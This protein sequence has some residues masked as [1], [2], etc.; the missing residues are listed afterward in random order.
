MSCD[1]PVTIQNHLLHHTPQPDWGKDQQWNWPSS[2][3]GFNPD[4]LFT[5]LHAR[6]NSVPCA[7][8]DPYGWHIDVCDVAN[9]AQ[10]PAEF[11]TL[12]QK[13]QEER[14]A[15]LQQAWDDTSTQLVSQISRW[16]VPRRRSD[17]WL[18]F[19]RISRNFS[20][21]SILGYFGSYTGTDPTPHQ[22]QAKKQL[23][24]RRAEY[25]RNN[26]NAAPGTSP[27]LIPLPASLGG[28]IPEVEPLRRETT[29][30]TDEPSIQNNTSLAV[31]PPRQRSTS[32]KQ[33]AEAKPSRRATR[34]PNK[35]V[36]RR[37]RRNKAAGG[38]PEPVRRSARLQQ[39]AEREKR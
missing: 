12:L 10:T 27:N 24:A 39:R 36:K 8:Q 5:D 16:D 31:E 34:S 6:F 38:N 9:E 14:F 18:Q 26:P 19:V 4:I 35:V 28:P 7:I 2:K 20:Y 33:A 21:D 30:P 15:E 11:Y 17:L 3:F 29:S 25:R 37:T 22:M 13:R 1:E 32:P 23:Q